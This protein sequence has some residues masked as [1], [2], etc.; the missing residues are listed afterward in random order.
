MVVLT[1]AAGAARDQNGVY[2]VCG[3]LSQYIYDVLNQ[4]GLKGQPPAP[5][6]R[7]RAAVF[8]FIRSAR[9]AAISRPCARVGAF[10]KSAFSGSRP[11]SQD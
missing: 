2:A 10:V 6:K 3:D 5:L 9:V 8:Y 4:A 7:E 1:V 11:Q